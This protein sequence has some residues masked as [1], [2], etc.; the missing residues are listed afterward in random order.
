MNKHFSLKAIVHCATIFLIAI[1]LLDTFIAFGCPGCSEEAEFYENTTD[2]V[3]Y[4]SDIYKAETEEIYD[5]DLYDYDDILDS[6]NFSFD[7]DELEIPYDIEEYL[8]DEEES[9]SSSWIIVLIIIIVAII[10]IAVVLVITLSSKKNDSDSYEI[11]I[12][13]TDQKQNQSISEA[14]TGI[15]AQSERGIL[16][17]NGSMAGYTVTISDGETLNL[18]KDAKIAGLVFSSDYTHV[19]RLHCTISY[20]ANGNSYFVTDCSSNGTFANGERLPTGK[21]ISVSVGTVLVLA[22][23]NCKIKLL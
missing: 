12:R 9:E 6:Y 15:L 2:A 19:S 8:E 13:K 4:E 22:D 16:V 21:R 1:I 14:E 23:D 10:I 5:Y 20:S 18:G 11:P 3:V 17:L 7:E